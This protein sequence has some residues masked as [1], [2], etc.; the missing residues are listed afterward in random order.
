MNYCVVSIDWGG[1]YLRGMLK[2]R[3]TSFTVFDLPS[4][5]IRSLSL[6][7]IDKT[8]KMIVAKLKLPEKKPC[9]W[10]AGVAG[11]GDKSSVS[12]LKSRL[13][14]FSPPGSKA[15]VYPDYECN[16]LASMMDEDGIL[17][18][19]GTGS[20]IYC[21]KDGR[22]ARFG[23]LGFMIDDVPSGAYWGQKALK[24]LL[25]SGNDFEEAAL[26][27]KIAKEFNVAGQ[28]QT[29]LRNLYSHKQPQKYLAQ[30]AYILTMAYEQGSRVAEEIVHKSVE[31]LC[32][33]IFK[34]T[35]IFDQKPVKICGFG[36]LWDNWPHFEVIMKEK[37]PASKLSFVKPLYKS[38]I[39]P[40][41]KYNFQ[42][43][44]QREL[45]FEAREEFKNE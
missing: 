39:G 17:C 12:L 35:E 8:V 43:G 45:L 7:D 20:V 14:F 19:N 6:Q 11:G 18:V 13:L 21:K 5:N 24:F 16:Y 44:E 25:K 40:L 2:S 28:K 15:H 37:C 27:R 41:V 30:F 33:D 29:I 38:F 42:T 34:A 9:L 32:K 26:I 23:G 31:R 36:G 1:T 22:Y 3:D 10:L 4:A